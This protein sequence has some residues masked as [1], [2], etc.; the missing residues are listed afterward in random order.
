L[1]AELAKRLARPS[2][3]TTAGAVLPN[4]TEILMRRILHVSSAASW[5]GGEQQLAYLIDALRTLG[6]EQLLF[7]PRNSALAREAARRNW[8]HQTYT[9]GFSLNPL[10]AWNLARTARKWK[11]DILHTHDSHSHGFAC[12]AASLFGLRAPLVVS[13][14]VDFP[15]SGHILSRWKYNH[16]SVKSIL[17]VSE[18]ILRILKPDIRDGSKLAVVHSGIDLSRFG[19]GDAGLLR[20]QFDIPK[21]SPI[22]GNVAAMADHKDPL[23]F[24]RTA[25]HLLAQRPELRF[26]WIG[27]NGGMEAEVRAMAQELKLD[28]SLFFT[29]FRNDIP[30]LLSE[31]D[32]FLFTSKTEGLGTSV[33]DAFAAGVPVVASRAGGIPEMVEHEQTGL[34]APVGDE[35]EFARQVL[36]LLNAPVLREQ[37]VRGARQRVKYFS[38][39]AT[40]KKTL[41]YYE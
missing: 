6:L 3:T 19:H 12:M 23:T 33:L 22:I 14:R 10:A 34:L 1:E 35:A 27:G 2:E 13:R 40:A 41:A 38:C 37:V 24:L 17:C 4:S 5:R 32:V 7:C 36:R 20:S 8:P 9:K 28:G 31:L 26:V 18:E 29:G 15:I 11:A 30:E 21:N 39:E 16:S 25:A